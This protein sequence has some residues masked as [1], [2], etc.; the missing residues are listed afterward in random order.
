MP[1]DR[2]SRQK[3]LETG[4]VPT[5]P[6]KGETQ[7]QALAAIEAEY[8]E[9]ERAIKKQVIEPRALNTRQT[10]LNMG[11]KGNSW[12]VY[13]NNAY[14]RKLAPKPDWAPQPLNL[15]PEGIKYETELAAVG[16][17][18]LGPHESTTGRGRRRLKKTAGRRRRSRRNS[19]SAMLGK[20]LKMLMGKKTRK[21]RGSSRRH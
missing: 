2:S 8:K 16:E 14:A 4:S 15:S 18:Q 9:D 13:N 19:L 21:H 11:S 3:R 5:G 17:T 7:A 6:I 1:A 12:T 20:P 10:P